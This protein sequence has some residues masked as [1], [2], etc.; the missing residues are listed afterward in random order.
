VSLAPVL[1]PVPAQEEAP[2]VALKKASMNA[3]SAK[4]QRSIHEIGYNN[5]YSRNVIIVYI[6]Y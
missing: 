3:P 2:P 4:N 6:M 5:E 1:V